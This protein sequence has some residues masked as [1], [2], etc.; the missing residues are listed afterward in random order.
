[1]NTEELVRAAIAGWNERG[2]EGLLEF[3]APDVV[4]HSP[5]DYPEGQ[6]WHGRE[7]LAKAWHEQFDS[8]FEDARSD[9][10]ALEFGPERYFATLRL[11]GRGH[12]SGM[13]FDWLTYFVGRVDEGLIKEVW[14]FTD[15]DEA[16]RQAG[17]DAE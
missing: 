10:E 6:E 3:A 12:G 15:K 4:W 17:L 7:A 9:M 5:P 13:V 2:I 14:L 11:H 16:R 8:V 1:M